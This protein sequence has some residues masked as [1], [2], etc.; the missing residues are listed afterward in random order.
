MVSLTMQDMLTAAIEMHRSGQLGPA[1]QLYQ[2]VLARE[3]E[4]AEALHLL[5]VLHHQQGNHTRAVELIGR[6]VALRPNSHVYHA[7]LAEAYR[8]LG[9]FDRAAGCCRA[10][11]SIWPDYPEALSNLG[12]AL[13]GLGQHAES[14]E[15]LRR[16]LDLRP[17]FVVAHNN[18]GIALRELGQKDEAL[19][20]FRRA[21]E[22]EPAFA[23]AQTNLGQSLLDRGQGDLAL[24]HCQEA[25]RLDPNSAVLHHNLGNVLRVLERLVDAKAS[26]LEALR[27][28]PKLAIANAHLGLVLQRE[29]QLADGL[30]WL[31]KA[32]ELEPD[33]IGF[34]EWLAELYDEMEEPAESI[35]CWER[36]IALD[37]DRAGAHL[38][39][40]WAFQEEGRLAE[41]RG[42]YDTA[43]HLQPEL[44]AAYL[45]VG[46]LQEELGDLAGAEAAFRTALR[47]QPTYALPHARLATLLRGKLPDQ[48]LAALEERLTDE[49][50]GQA[51]RARL[52]FSLAHAMDGRG[53]YVRAAECLREGN[54]LTV[55]VNEKRR[56]YAPVEHERFID[57]VLRVFDRDLFARLAGA[58]SQ[59]LRPIFVFGL[60]RSG[61]TLIEQVLASHSQIHGAGELRL[62]RRSF[63]AIPGLLGRTGPP[64]DSISFLDQQTV[65]RLAEQHLEH[66]AAI[67]GCRNPRIVDKMPDNYMYIGLL[68]ILFPNAVF[69][70]SRRDLRDVA[71]S[72]W[73][74]DFR[75]IRW[76][77]DLS[78][79]A[80][81]CQQYERV[82][83]HW[84][85]VLPAKIHEV[86]YEQT[87]TDL[88][89][90]AR[91]LVAA[92]GLPWEQACLEFHRTERP[93][94]TASVMQVRQPVYQRSVARWKHYQPALGELFAALPQDPDPPPPEST[95]CS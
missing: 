83:S 75:S 67:D 68:S 24:P 46:G 65:A 78:H 92:C 48:D 50:L 33:N 11:L 16:A 5:G 84:K 42:H 71:V 60:P 91:R 34:W 53:D 45:N 59:S 62:A 43:I 66:L 39:L 51:P 21:V 41:A 49:K 89:S 61:T 35:P 8:A 55:L 9:D 13:Q 79:I 64:R 25:V 10:A 17:N 40:G 4:N 14:V 26:Y 77:N 3:Q 85:E 32:S 86:N 18:L 47:F 28:N 1:S 20:H 80:A 12:A 37:P 44:A 38:S 27:L 6:A 76:A 90:V 72:C 2:K 15:Q 63:E 88:E 23:P 69:V 93:I 22:L 36:V 56:D 94:R 58:G 95:T 57:G 7:N 81:R 82:M 52:L 70:H 54:A 74:T 73:M 31:K 30:V 87:V 19:E 29:G